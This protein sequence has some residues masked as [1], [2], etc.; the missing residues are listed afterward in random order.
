MQA[1][2]ELQEELGLHPPLVKLIGRLEAV[3]L[4][5]PSSAKE[6]LV[7]PFLFECDSSQEL[8]LNWENDEVQW[9]DPS[10]L[11]MPDS[12][13]WQVPLVRALLSAVRI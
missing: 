1:Y 12:V 13:R 9:A 7:H 11:E 10:R 6:F 8:V 4:S 3:P 5:S 2:T